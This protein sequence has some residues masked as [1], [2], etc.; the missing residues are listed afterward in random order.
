LKVDGWFLEWASDLWPDF[1][2]ETDGLD[3]IVDR[4][5]FLAL[6]AYM[7]GNMTAD[8]TEI[9]WMAEVGTNHRQTAER[10][11]TPEQHPVQSQQ[12]SIDGTQ[13]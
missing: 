8:E 12:S 6:E 7:S 2:F 10:G 13:A 3:A 11:P 9:P 1:A 4:V 5:E